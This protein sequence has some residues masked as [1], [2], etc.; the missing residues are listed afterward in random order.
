M[1]ENAVAVEFVRRATSG[2]TGPLI[3]TCLTDAGE[4]IE[5]FCKL[6]A[7]CDEGVTNLAREVVGACLAADLG[8]PVPKPFLVELSQEFIGAVSDP[9]T[10]TR[11]RESAPVAFG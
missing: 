7:G 11:M 3:L 10:A 8:L 2:R 1:L 5:L 4:A 6:S 9:K